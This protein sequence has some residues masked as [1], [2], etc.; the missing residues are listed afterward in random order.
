M[1][2]IGT[3]WISVPCLRDSLGSCFSITLYVIWSS[4]Y[5]RLI[6]WLSFILPTI[7]IFCSCIFNSS[8]NPPRLILEIIVVP[9][10]QTPSV[11]II[12]LILR[13][14]FLYSKSVSYSYSICSVRE[15]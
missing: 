4:W 2:L 10:I 9:Y 11:G 6:V 14:C 3:N 13:N 1:G 7:Y 5:I 15:G 8:R 12:F